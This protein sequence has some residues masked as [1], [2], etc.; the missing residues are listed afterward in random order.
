VPP[1]D[2]QQASP[3]VDYSRDFAR[4]CGAAIVVAAGCTV[5]SFLV[6]AIVLYF[7]LR[8]FPPP[9]CEERKVLA[10]LI[11]SDHVWA[12]TVYDNVCSDGGFVTT[13]DNTIEITSPEENTT[14]LPSDTATIFGMDARP[15]SEPPPVLSWTGPRDLEVTL[16]Y[17]A[18][19]EGM[20][21][22]SRT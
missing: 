8:Q 1:P 14:P 9:N 7:A 22:G 20:K 6:L 4:G 17:G 15:D 3:Q 11:S 2:S 5:A 10:R 19:V 13:V 16:P 18:S 21:R 12:A